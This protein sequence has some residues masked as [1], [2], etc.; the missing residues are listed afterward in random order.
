MKKIL[1]ILTVAIVA[2]SINTYAQYSNDA[3]R[4]SQTNYGSSARF[5]GMGNAQIGVGGDISSISGNPAG[6]G[7]FTRSEFVFTPE[8]NGTTANSSF[9]GNTSTTNKSQLNLNQ[10]GVVFNMP[11]YRM[12]GQDT[13]KG[14]VSATIGVSYNRTND[15]GAEANFSGTNTSTSVINLTGD[16]SFTP[17]SVQSTN[18]SR[19]G[20]VSEFNIAGALNISNQ[21]YIGATLGLINLRYD[22]NSMLDEE[23]VVDDYLTNYDINQATKGSGINAKLGVIFRPTPEFRIG[24]NLQTPTWFNIDEVYSETSNDAE[25]NFDPSNFSYNLRTPMKGSLGAS[26]VFGGRALISA[27]VDYVDYST[28]KFSS[29]DGGDMNVINN[30]NKDV[31]TTFRSAINYRVGGEV[32]VNDFISLR[33]GYGNNGSAYKDD[34]DEQFFATQF[35]SGGLGYRNKNYY[36]DLAYQRVNTNATFSPYQLGGLEPVAESTNNKNNVFLTF[37]LRF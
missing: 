27:D 23:G 8:F 30:N 5:K 14:L 15:Y 31:R 7:L 33:A 11:T 20:S 3:L 34:K 36:F 24:A 32:K 10:L 12:K 37:G 1:S 16:N 26:Y 28:I 21:I 29:A 17:N 4:F 19:S 9:L 18:I 22:Y 13:Q 25:L 2:T 6:L 35:Y